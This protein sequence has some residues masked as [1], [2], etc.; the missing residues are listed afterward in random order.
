MKLVVELHKALAAELNKL[1]ISAKLDYSSNGETIVQF[2][3][4]TGLML[5]VEIYNQ[6][7]AE[8]DV[9]PL[10]DILDNLG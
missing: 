1:G 8:H 9:V 4:N 10:H 5:F 6:E 7:T 2:G 3:S